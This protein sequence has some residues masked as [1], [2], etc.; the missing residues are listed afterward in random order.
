[1]PAR[2]NALAGRFHPDQPDLLVGQEVC[3]DA[4]GV[5]AAA[6]ASDAPSVA[7]NDASA[8]LDAQLRALIDELGLTGD[9]SIGRDL[10]S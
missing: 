10:P 5:G 3:E 4:D 2:R 8:E 1:M 9:P 7:S 6:N